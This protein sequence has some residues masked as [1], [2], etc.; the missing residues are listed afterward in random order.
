[1]DGIAIPL[2]QPTFVRRHHAARRLLLALPVVAIVVA[3]ILANQ[4]R[5]SFAY[6]GEG[7]TLPLTQPA[8]F[9]FTWPVAR[10]LRVSVSPHVEGEVRFGKPLVGSRGARSVA[11]VPAQTWQP[12]TT[13]QV[14]LTDVESAVPGLQRTAEY[15]FSFTTASAPGVSSIS[16]ST[17][18]VLAADAAWRVTLDRPV[19]TTTQFDFSLEP[20]IPVRSEWNEAERA[21]VVTPLQLLPQGASVT[22]RV[23]R[24]VRR[25]AFETQEVEGQGE[26]ETLATA[27]W[28]VRTAPGV[29]A[30]LPQGTN[31]ALTAP[32]SVTLTE[33]ADLQAFTTSVSLSPA[34]VGEWVT[35]DD[36]TFTLQHQPLAQRTTYTLKLA[37]T[38]RTKSGGFVP[39]NVASQFST[40]GPVV[41][42][43]ASPAHS[44]KGVGV[45]SSLRF[46]F[47]QTVD[48]TSAEQ[49]FRISPATAGKFS[50]KDATLTFTPAKPLAFDTT[51]TVVLRAGIVGAAG[52]PSAADSTVQF[53][54][55][56]AVTRLAVPYHRQEHA[57]SCEIATLVM[58]LRYRGV[59]I[60]EQKIIDAIGFDPTPKKNGIW[61]DPDI[62]FVGD[63]DGQQPGTGYGVNAAPIAKAGS[64]YRTT[65]AFKN[66]SLTAVLNEVKAGNPVIVW[67]NAASGR[68][69][70]WKTPTG[71]T[72]L[73]IVGEHTRV[74]VG[75][76]GSAENPTTIITLDPLYGEKRFT[77]AAFLADWARLGNMGVVV[78]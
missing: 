69:V 52:F 59:S 39:E 45:R 36:T 40:I 16:P 48:R 46:T 1:M 19:D 70:D 47:D 30:F 43:S 31:Q 73:A 15:S 78:E 35:T 64:A 54:T 44:A 17:D 77:K 62:A 21:Y 41:L 74:V 6:Q 67:G 38:L 34:V 3:V 7:V 65:R 37:P 10:T 71:K 32:I 49:R 72:V 50:W 57:L 20:N 11:F 66:G 13:Y 14:T 61:G 23:Q 2:A 4:P 8:E 68:R 26:A 24:T 18:T 12:N 76:V 60:G 22:L 33:P 55:E 28:Q 42:A 58:A 9:T 56:H 5:P 51:Y 29:A 25:L 27:M 75:F 63:I 53:A